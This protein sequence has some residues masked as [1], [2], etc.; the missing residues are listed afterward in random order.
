MAKSFLKDPDSVLDYAF[1]W[2][3]WL[4]TNETISDYTITVES[5]IA[6]DSDS[7]SGSIVTVWLTGGTA[8]DKYTVACEIITSLGRTDERS[9]V[10]H[11]KNR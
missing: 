2:S 11:V 9:M 4:E 6:K 10:I 1:D 5:G 3:D 8:G 7:E